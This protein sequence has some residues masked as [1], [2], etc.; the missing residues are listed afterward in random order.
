MDLRRGTGCV[1]RIAHYHARLHH[2]AL[3][4]HG[5][6]E[7]D[8]LAQHLEIGSGRHHGQG[9]VDSVVVVIDFCRTVGHDLH[10]H[11]A[12]V[13]AAVGLQVGGH[14]Y[15]IPDL[16]NAIS[17]PGIEPELGASGGGITVVP[18]NA[19]GVGEPGTHVGDRDPDM[20][21]GALLHRVGRDQVVGDGD[22]L[23]VPDHHRPGGQVV[24]LVGLLDCV[25]RVSP[26]IVLVRSRKTEGLE[27]H[28]IGEL[29]PVALHQRQNV[30]RADLGPA[31]S[32]VAVEDPDQHVRGVHLPAVP[33]PSTDLQPVP[34]HWL[35][36][37]KLDPLHDDD[38]VHPLRHPDR[39]GGDVVGL[40]A[41]GD[42]VVRIRDHVNIVVA[43][44]Q[45]S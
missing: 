41:L 14:E 45:H 3:D 21:P 11:L 7:R 4:G 42:G 15:R 18:A 31:R 6:R 9:E 2:F 16:E 27:G 28:P 34:V 20:G 37:G 38:Q 13:R 10:E 12:V 17:A 19:K 23:Q 44:G 43:V 5:G 32:R 40:V 24:V 29:R 26:Y 36:V 30:V 35:V 22:V 33:D 1:A 8:V 25:F 39:F